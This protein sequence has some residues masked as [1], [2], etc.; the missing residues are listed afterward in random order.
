MRSERF[1]RAKKFSRVGESGRNFR[2]RFSSLPRAAKKGQENRVSFGDGCGFSAKHR[3]LTRG[4]GDLSAKSRT[5]ER[6]RPP[7]VS[8]V[9]QV[10]DRGMN[11]EVAKPDRHLSVAFK[12]W[13]GFARLRI[14]MQMIV[15]GGT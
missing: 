9:S 12:N 13:P 15:D 2:R 11:F 4:S 1:A 14:A 8:G 6:V 3:H 7:N 10:G 5:E